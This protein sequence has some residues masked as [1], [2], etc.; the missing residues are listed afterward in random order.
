[1]ATTDGD[2]VKW[3]RAMDQHLAWAREYYNRIKDSDHPN[4][5]ALEDAMD[6]NQLGAFAWCTHVVSHCLNSPERW[7]TGNFGIRRKANGE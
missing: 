6:G 3:A 5:S 1:M 2:V 4:A 7:E